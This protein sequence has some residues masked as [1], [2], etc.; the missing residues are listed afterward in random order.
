MT[1]TI[2]EEFK[3][4]ATPTQELARKL[5]SLASADNDSIITGMKSTKGQGSNAGK[6]EKVKSDQFAQWFQ[7]QSLEYQQLYNDTWS[8]LQDAQKENAEELDRVNRELKKIKDSIKEMNENAHKLPD[9][10]AVYFTEDHSAAYTADGL[11]LE[12]DEIGKLAWNDKARPWE[13]FDAKDKERDKKEAERDGRLETKAK[14]DDFEKEM[15]E[16]Q[17]TEERLKEIRNDFDNDFA[18]LEAPKNQNINPAPAN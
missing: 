13:E 16:G 2:G 5:L 6:A 11:K 12:D 7:Q 9:G 4:V 18:E 15:Q 1:L 10:T 3:G 17:P 14:L 8:D